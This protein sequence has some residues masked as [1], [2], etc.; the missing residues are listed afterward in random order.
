MQ[1]HVLV[2]LLRSSGVSQW[3]QLAAG[4]AEW[5]TTCGR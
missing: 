5:V 4:N 3:A 2:V 1:K